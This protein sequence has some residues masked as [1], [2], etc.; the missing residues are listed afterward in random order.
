M[1]RPPRA[2]VVGGCYHVLNRGNGRARIFRKEADFLAFVR[3]LA[4]GLRRYPVDLL[5]WCLMHNHWHL[6]L[7]PR[8][9]GAISD[10]M[11]W[12]GVTHVRR[13]HQQH[14]TRGG[15]HVYQGRFKSFAIEAD[16]HFLLV[17]RYVEAN[18]RRAGLVKSAQQWRWSSL[19][20]AA[21]DSAGDSPGGGPKDK[22][23]VPLSDWPVD[24]PGNWV[25]LV[26]QT[27][28][29]AQLDRLRRSVQRGTP[30][31]AERWALRTARRLGLLNTIRPP[32]RPRKQKNQ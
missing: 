15:G 12:I 3:V 25:E 17:C 6:V 21:G 26:N 31:G 20:Y 22:P 11:R 19:G 30:F 24:R 8:R 10:L 1:P 13:H 4:E 27:M 18:P 2:F 7:R 5:C 16:R 28:S 23:S 14:G 9:A 29:K 32:G